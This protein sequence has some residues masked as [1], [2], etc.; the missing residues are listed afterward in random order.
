MRPLRGGG[1]DIKRI[2]GSSRRSQLQIEICR[3]AERRPRPWW[4]KPLI[5][6]ASEPDLPGLG[7]SF[8]Y[9]VKMTWLQLL[10]PTERQ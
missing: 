1:G 4:A 8:F 7:N 3:A 9:Q 10:M 2:N 5:V 6:S